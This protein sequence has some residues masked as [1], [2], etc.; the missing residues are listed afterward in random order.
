M[1]VV[2]HDDA[3]VAAGL[4]ERGIM[5]NPLSA[6]GLPGHIRISFGTDEENERFFVALREVLGA[7]PAV[8]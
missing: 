4:L 6:W 1:R 3:A 7:V 2:V 5:I 8:V